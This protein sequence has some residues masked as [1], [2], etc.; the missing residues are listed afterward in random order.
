MAPAKPE[1]RRPPTPRLRA[2][3]PAERLA[4]RQPTPVPAGNLPTAMPP[5]VGREAQIAEV[6]GLAESSRL[7][8]LT[9]PSGIGKTRLALEVAARLRDDY[10]GGAW[11]VELAPVADPSLV[12]QAVA[13]ALGLDPEPGRD[14]TDAVVARLGR[15]SSLVVLDNCEHLLGASADLARRLMDDCRWLRVLA[16]SQQSL[17][18]PEEQVTAVAP[19]SLPPAGLGTSVEEALGAEAVALF[20]TR[21][22][23]SSPGFA[24]T[25]EVLAPVAEI[26]NRLDGI[27]LAIELAA[28]RIAAL[29][30]ADIADRLEQRFPL[31]TGGVHSADARHQTLRAALDWSYD[32]LTAEEATLLRR[33]SVFAAGALLHAVEDV[34]GGKGVPRDDIVD[35]LAS[36][37]SKSLVI[38]DTHRARARYRLLE[39]VRTYGRE[40]LEEEGQTGAI[41]ARHAAWCLARVERAWHQITAGDSALWTQGLEAELD[42]I[43]AALA[44]TIAAQ[45]PVA[46]RLASALTPF[47]KTR[48]YFREGQIWLTRALVGASGP[49]RTRALWG[50]GMLAT[51]QGD[52]EVA[53]PAAEECLAL[54]RAGRFR[55]AEAQA[56][57]LLG[58]ISIFTQDSLAAKPL[59]EESVDLARADG[60]AGSLVSALGLL[61]RAHLFLGDI[62]G[63]R[64][65]FEECL[66]V[67]EHAGDYRAGALIGLG[68]TACAAGEL[69]HAEKLFRSALPI[70]RA[71]GERFETALAL[72][73]LGELTWARGD[74]AGARTL[75]EE[76]RDL[77]T[78]MGAPFPLSRSL[79]GLARVAEAEGD[80]G[81]ASET[82]EEGCALA[83]SA[84]L[85][86]ALVRALHVGGDQRRAAGDADGA[87]A[88]YEEALGL[89]RD[90]GDRGGEAASV[91]RLALLARVRGA[92]DEA[93][94]RLQD[95][96]TLQAEIGDGGLFSSLEAMAGVAADQGRAVLAAGL[97]GAAAGLREGCGSPC[98]PDEAARYEAD[99][100]RLRGTL[101]PDRLQAAWAQGAALSREEAAA[102]A[103]RGKGPRDRPHHGWGSLSP[104]ERQ[105]ADLVAEGL[106]NREIGEQMFISPRTVQGHLSRIFPKLG[107]TSRRELREAHRQR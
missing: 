20:C 1:K 33:M 90:H 54:A 21:A 63:A 55:R 39:T 56:L 93:A 104:V 11:L 26:C 7:I 60:D 19:L 78:V 4:V 37:V 75:L 101:D 74:L 24:L 72:S 17:G 64:E 57:N 58:F 38:A 52:I 27:P 15:T 102:L 82:A 98:P 105:I 14:P 83:R 25:D 85:P 34:C 35:L 6:V 36:L 73:F 43:R 97:L 13:T 88:A 3:D 41:R 67:A 66:R 91:Y 23:S 86:Y 30:A 22:A 96:L 70:L 68:W 80:L 12:A 46:L 95:A 47:W 99:V 65:V 94:T 2:V 42:N 28:A 45:P 49:L 48:G 84:R 9:G 103:T 107:V 8:T 16:T 53:R 81:A 61:G 50:I 31:L 59:L 44:W 100:A 5:F 79:W 40:R 51:L 18:V 106:T 71:T 87:R 77:A 29:G 10:P 32:L 62:R 92:D 69:D 89:A 76:G